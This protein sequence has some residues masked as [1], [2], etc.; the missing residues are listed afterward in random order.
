MEALATWETSRRTRKACGI[1]QQQQ[2]GTAPTLIRDTPQVSSLLHLY[3]LFRIFIYSA[4]LQNNNNTLTFQ[5][6]ERETH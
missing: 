4:D 6:R 1:V 2:G 5:D 3:T